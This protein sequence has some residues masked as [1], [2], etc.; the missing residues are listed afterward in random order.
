MSGATAALAPIPAAERQL[1]IPIGVGFFT[2]QL[3]MTSAPYFIGAYAREHGLSATSGGTLFLVE[4]FMF[5]AVMLG[6]RPLLA[7][8]SPRWLVAVGTVLLAAGQWMSIA[9]DDWAVLVACRLVTGIASAFINVGAGSVAA[10]AQ[11]PA[12]VFGIANALTT[13]LCAGLYLASAAASDWRGSTGVFAMLGVVAL[14]SLPSLLLVPRGRAQAEEA[15]PPRGSLRAGLTALVALL[16]FNG[17]VNAIWPF[18]EQ[19][20]GDIGISVQ[21]FAAYQAIAAVLAAAGGLLAG[22][23]GARYGRL[24]P[25]AIGLPALGLAC[26]ALT[27]SSSGLGFLVAETLFLSTWYFVYAYVLDVAAS[28]DPS[29]HT[30]GL[31]AAGLPLSLGFGAIAGG[32]LIDLFSIPA[33]GLF[34]FVS[35]IVA[36]AVIAPAARR[37]DR[38]TTS[39]REFVE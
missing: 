22:R 4:M 12:R 19:L 13:L 30:V 38:T 27:R 9:A 31:T 6:S 17:G 33:V 35:T 10:R 8:V 2:A 23:L 24:L 1:A 29:G 20:A 15:P 37:L 16:I 34:G 25:L 21:R 36:L 39:H 18:L 32:A 26:I 28:A 5:G 3:S 7:R 11:D 14:L